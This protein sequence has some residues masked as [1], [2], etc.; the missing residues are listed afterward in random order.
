MDFTLPSLMA[1]TAD[2]TSI[3]PAYASALMRAGKLDRVCCP[4]PWLAGARILRA[5]G[6]YRLTDRFGGVMLLAQQLA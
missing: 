3:A 1:A 4:S 6:S 5:S 2:P